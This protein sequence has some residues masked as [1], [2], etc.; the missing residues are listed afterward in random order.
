MKW[1]MEVGPWVLFQ[2]HIKLKYF[3]GNL[4]SNDTYCIIGFLRTHIQLM[5]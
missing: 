5:H 4:F 3:T 2:Q 1:N